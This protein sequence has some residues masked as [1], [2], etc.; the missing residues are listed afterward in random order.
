[1]QDFRYITREWRERKET[2]LPVLRLGTKL[3]HHDC[4]VFWPTLFGSEYSY[5]H[6][7][8]HSVSYEFS[9]LFS[10]EVYRVSSPPSDWFPS[11]SSRRRFSTWLKLISQVS[12]DFTFQKPF[13]RQNSPRLSILR[14]GHK[15]TGPK[16]SS[17]AITE[18]AIREVGRVKLIDAHFRVQHTYKIFFTCDEDRE[19][20]HVNKDFSILMHYQFVRHTAETSVF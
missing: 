7:L 9:A 10:I 19:I 1:M 16:N 18:V 11:Y 15:K 13:F 4:A 8:P 20:F 3:F 12:L 6:L 5:F 17:D 14:L 2:C